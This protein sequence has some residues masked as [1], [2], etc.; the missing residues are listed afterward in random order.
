MRFTTIL[1]SVF[2]AA[3]LYGQSIVTPVFVHKDGEASASGY[4][5]SKKEILVSGGMDQVVGW[6]TFQTGGLDVSQIASARLT[7]YVKSLD[8]PGTLDIYPLS[9]EVTAPENIIAL[10]S[11]TVETTSIASVAL[12]NNDVEKIIQLDITSAVTGGSFYG[13]ALASDDGLRA[14]FDAKEGS[15]APMILLTH[16][17]GSAA[18]KWH[19]GT[20]DPDAG[21]GKDGDYYLNTATGDVLLKSGG[22]WSISMNITGATGPRGVQGPQGPKGDTGAQS[23]QGPKGDAGAQGPEGP[24]GPEGSFPAGTA[25]G[26]MQYWDGT[27]WVMI[28]AGKPGEVL[29]QSGSGV[30]QWL[31][32][33]GTVSDIDGNVY[34]TIV[35]GNQEWTVENW[36]CT[37][38][39]D[40]TDI[41]LVTD[42]D[43]WSELNT[44]AYC[45]YE[46]EIS[47]KRPYG[48]LYNWYVVD[49]SNPK[50]L[51]PD[52]W[53]VPNDADWTALQNY[54][55]ANGY[56]Y[57][58]T[59]SGNKIAKSIAA[60]V[61][62][63]NATAGV[64]GNDLS[65]N[66]KSGFSALPGGGR[67]LGVFA[68]QSYNSF[69]WSA[70][71]SNEFFAWCHRLYYSDNSLIKSE[72][73][74]DAGMSVRLVRDLE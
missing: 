70:T 67:I 24:Q 12:G 53:R 65:L 13:V 45:W 15:L 29:T 54:L 28:P 69:L 8:S 66:N 34:R 51:A 64:V 72:Y 62:F 41:P 14:I 74:K 52:G 68:N 73:N 58:G 6:F 44:A 63:S 59:T 40:G 47:N 1:L 3:T 25:A 35:I 32:M 71:Q 50:K 60:G 37:K 46:N 56:N 61:W 11:L 18:S 23:P 57:D 27:Q 33:P 10:S 49:P 55:T 38:Y 36:C 7:L 22:V 16:D 5:G 9:T 42:G 2:L 21:L 20:T 26:D 39:N 48:A 4:V 31:Q 43:T 19:S 17:V 30:P